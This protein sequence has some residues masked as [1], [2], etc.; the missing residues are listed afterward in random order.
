MATIGKPIFGPNGALV[1]D[2][3]YGIFPFVYESI[4][5]KKSK[6]RDVGAVEIKATQNVN[7]E[8]IR[9]MLINNVI[10]SIKAN[11][12]AYLPK[13]IFIQWDNARSHQIPRD[14][15]FETTCHSE[16]FNIQFIYQPAQSPDL[17]VLD[18]GLFNVIQSIQYQSFPKNLKELIE[19]VTE[20][21]QMFNPELNK[22]IWISL[23]CFM[24]EILI[25]QGGNNF[26]PP[27][28]GKKRLE[29][30]GMLPEQLEVDKNVVQEAVNYLNNIFIP[31]HQ[32][33]GIEEDEAMQVDAD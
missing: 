13:D 23:Q 25:N 3:K 28:K 27:H 5:K 15:E 1:H 32:G 22:Q 33:Q 8:A 7:K 31:V 18:L 11:W 9:A 21:Y 4:A 29:R 6:N 10:P 20:A 14:E 30:M 17:N 24:E 2:G 12:P 19:R 26:I 16:G